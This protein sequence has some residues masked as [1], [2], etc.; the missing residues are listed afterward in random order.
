[1]RGALFSPILVL[2]C[3]ATVLAQS[4]GTDQTAARGAWL[5]RLNDATGVA[6]EATVER[7]A[8]DPDTREESRSDSRVEVLLRCDERKFRFNTK[9]A[10]DRFAQVH[11]L[12]AGGF[13]TCVQSLP[14]KWEPKT[15]RT[16]NRN[17][18]WVGLYPFL[19][20][21]GVVP[22]PPFD[23]PHLPGKREQKG[24]RTESVAGKRVSFAF[25]DKSPLSAIVGHSSDG[26]IEQYEVAHGNLKV[27][28]CRLSY[29][30][31]K[32]QVCLDKFTVSQ[33]GPSGKL[34][35]EF[36]GQ[37]TSCWLDA[38][39][40]LTVF[41][42]PRSRDEIHAGLV[43]ALDKTALVKA[44]MSL[45]DLAESVQKALGA[46]TQVRIDAE[47]FARAG[48]RNIDALRFE[49]GEP[50]LADLLLG[51]LR[52]NLLDFY[53]DSQGIVL[54]PRR[55]AWGYAESVRYAADDYGLTVEELRNKIY[56]AGK[57]DDWSDVGGPA[58][59]LIGK[60]EP[61]I[62]V[63]H[64]QSDHLRFEEALGKGNDE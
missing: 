6:Y 53:V 18:S 48:L 51:E 42:P 46:D 30:R 31:E 50:I 47:S 5:K 21:H 54:I 56:N 26:F 43:K 15:E 64:T 23:A 12:D 35:G 19:L 58:M 40:P 7:V 55:E 20:A 16:V 62:E 44:E 45:K 25:A 36:E 8:T 2:V 32:G 52:A 60:N 27:L 3:S 49:P 14:G 37:V 59:M 28:E 9:A 17:S 39:I 11:I 41:L 13:H 63:L 57:L 4:S 1:M 34:A 33:Y 10:A 22:L 61:T 29:R 38:S 24:R